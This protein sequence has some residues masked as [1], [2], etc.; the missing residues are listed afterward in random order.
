[1]LEDN[2][3]STYSFDI[4]SQCKS[5]CCQDAK[6]PLSEKR[7]KIIQKYLAKKKIIIKEP[8]SK[9]QYSYPA[10]D[11]DIYCL[12]FNK[13]TGK[14]IVHPVKPDTC[15]SGP[16]T[17]DINFKT[18]KLEL[19]LKKNEICAYA[20]FLY[21]NKPKFKEHYQV[22]KKQITGLIK[23]LSAK[24]LRAI[25]KIDEPQ[26]FKVGEGD[27]PKEVVEKLGLQKTRVS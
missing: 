22:A 23:Q 13:N 20:G 7:R 8:F 12:F 5:I 17:F 10:V 4:C 25:V 15:I 16:I 21:Q 24:E 19:F 11:H 9:E 6:P 14:C 27:L 3:G 2:N 18:G 1:M 26:T